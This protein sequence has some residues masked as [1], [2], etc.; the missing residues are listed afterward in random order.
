MRDHYSPGKPLSVR[1][2]V[3][4]MGIACA[5]PYSLRSVVLDVSV[6]HFK[7][8]VG[9]CVCLRATLSCQ[10]LAKCRVCAAVLSDNPAYKDWYVTV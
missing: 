3:P 7:V 10:A 8:D 2:K 9:I 1:R 6:R 5:Q 4:P